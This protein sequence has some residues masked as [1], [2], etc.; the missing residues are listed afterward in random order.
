ML[1][2]STF[3]K[4]RQNLVHLQ[5]QAHLNKR[6]PKLQRGAQ[7]LFLIQRVLIILPVENYLLSVYPNP[8]KDFILLKQGEGLVGQYVTIYDIIRRIIFNE[9]YKN[10][11]NINFLE[12][13][14]YTFEVKD[15]SGKLYKTKFIKVD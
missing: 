5:K 15:I 12:A 8:S 4:E 7:I 3:E 13:G 14:L 2:L 1:E 9:K 6:A 10:R 11:I